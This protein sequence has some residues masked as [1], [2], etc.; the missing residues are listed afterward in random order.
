[1]S[2]SIKVLV[3][4]NF[5]VLHPG[6][7]RLLRFAKEQGEILIVGVQ[8]DRLAGASAY[9]PE[10]LRLEGVLSNNLVTDA[11]IFDEP[12]ENLVKK[13]RPDIVVKGKEH[14][15]LENPEI[16][17]LQKYGGKLVFSSG[18]NFFSSLDLINK[19]IQGINKSGKFSSP[20]YISRHQIKLSRL[21][22][23]VDNFRKLKVCVI[24]DLILDEYVTCE[25]LGMSQEDPTIVVTPIDTH[26]FIGGAGIVAAHAAS[27]G[28]ETSLLSIVGDDDDGKYSHNELKKYKVKPK[29]FIDNTRPTTLKRRYRSKGKSLLKVSKLHQG[30]ISNLLQ[31][32]IFN[33][34]LEIINDIDV[35][36]FSDFNY[37]SLPQPLVEKIICAANENKLLITADSQS[38]SQIGD[39]CRY[40]NVNLITPTER[41]ARISLKNNDDGLIV[42]A[43][44]LIRK[45]YAKNVF[46]KL[47]EEGFVIHS[48]GKKKEWLSD[49][50]DALNNYPKDVAGA[51][52]SL[53]IV[54]SMSLASNATIWEAAYLGAIAAGIQVSRVGN[55]PITSEELL[56]EV[57]K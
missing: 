24:G 55:K 8:S 22:K 43:E 54:A 15:N 46:L 32:K 31:E 5:N 11:F 45:T 14:E 39:I 33:Y 23:T 3:Y 56:R 25:S 13:Y 12:V 38:S 44:E 50:I 51:G 53:L 7:L 6:H 19:E 26:R 35:L 2:K 37:G 18:E 16:K 1:M 29:L 4:G 42:L 17:V 48:P 40:K 30:F 20:D 52:D 9:L 27:L 28:A 57:R 49:K 34:F 21:V 10:R 36:V 41:E 47:G